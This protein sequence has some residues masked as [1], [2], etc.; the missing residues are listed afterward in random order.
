[1][2]PLLDQKH[3]R[4]EVNLEP[5]SPISIDPVRIG[6]VVNNLISNA[7]KFSPEHGVITISARSIYENNRRFQ[8]I[9]VEDQGPGIVPYKKKL[10][11]EKYAQLNEEAEG[12]VK[13]SGLGLAVSRLIIEAHNGTIGC[14]D[15]EQ[16]GTI[17]FFRIPEDEEEL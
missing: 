5:L 10:I 3:N 11:F 8:E 14:Q 13:G 9:A 4:F 6:Q 2:T 7:I 12:V 15:G 1:M 16:T 17:F